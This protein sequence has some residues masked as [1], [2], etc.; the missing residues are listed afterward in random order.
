MARLS[1]IACSALVLAAPL[2]TAAGGE[3]RPS[4]V[5]QCVATSIKAIGTRLT[6]GGKPI[7]GSGSEVRFT[8][9]VR[10]VSY[11]TV[12]SI[13]RSE[14]GDPVRICLV[15]LPKDCPPGD[16]RGRVYRTTNLRTSEV[17]RLPD[18]EHMCGGA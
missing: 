4:R 11:E 13:E 12:P 2:N 6:D 18:S 1:V 15:E 14:T 3:R 7:E 5:G 16:D 10:Q 17:W 9:G 8:N